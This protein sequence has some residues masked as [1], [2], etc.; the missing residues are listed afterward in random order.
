MAAPDPVVG[1]PPEFT[2]SQVEFLE[3][4]FARRT[5]EQEERIK[6]A[7]AMQIATQFVQLREEASHA[8]VDLRQQQ[9]VATAA[10]ATATAEGLQLTA[11]A[12]RVMGTGVEQQLGQTRR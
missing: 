8:R 2:L 12:Q 9:D 5:A 3:G 1:G 11:Q 7:L 4:Q 6:A 10:D